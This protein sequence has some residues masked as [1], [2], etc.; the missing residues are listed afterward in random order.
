MAARERT[1]KWERTRGRVTASLHLASPWPCRREQGRRRGGRRRG[2]GSGRQEDST[3]GVL[4]LGQWGQTGDASKRVRERESERGGGDDGK[5]S[6][7]HGF[8]FNSVAFFARSN[9]FIL[10]WVMQ[11]LCRLVTSMQW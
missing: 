6:K 8:A 1:G 5:V 7:V 10:W 4:G 2:L 9:F 11:S 3:K